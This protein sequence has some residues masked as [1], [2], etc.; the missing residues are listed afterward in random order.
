MKMPNLEGQFIQNDKIFFVAA[1]ENY[2]ND[3]GKSLINSIRAHF[4]EGIHF[5]LYNPSESTLTYCKNHNIGHSYEFFDQSYVND[6]FNIYKT[7]S[8]DWEFLRRRQKMIKIGEDVEKIRSE[9]VRAYYACARFVRL[10]QLLSK[11]TY[12]IMLDTDS[13]VK[14]SFSL[15]SDSY[16]IHIFEKT[17]RKHVN[18]TQHLAS[19]I[20]YTGT[21]ASRK[22]IKEHSDLILEEF[23]QNTFYWFLDQETLDIVIQ[24]YRKNPLLK[25]FVDFD[26]NKSSYIWCAKGKRKYQ[27]LWL[28]EIEKFQ[29]L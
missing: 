14:K 6:A 24:K 22:L 4:N 12:V 9:L 20:F 10:D 13:L 23:T 15:P 5:H 18:Y 1:D 27:K 26:M 19:T 11:P 16:D 29:A 8:E 21:L 2:F 3:Y 17:H 28:E 25:E 7:P